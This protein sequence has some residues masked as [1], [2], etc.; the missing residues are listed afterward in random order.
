MTRVFSVALSAIDEARFGIRMARALNVSRADVEPMLAYCRQHQVRLLVARCAA[1]DLAAAQ[2]M[3]AEG[4]RL[5]DTLVHYARDLRRESL[6]ALPDGLVVRPVSPDE[7]A[8]IGQLAARTF[9]G[10]PGHYHADDRLDRRRAD[11]VYI[12]WA[13]RSCAVQD[14]AGAVLAAECNGQLAGFIS[15]RLVSASAAEVP[16]YG[17]DPAFQRQGVGRGLL[18]GGLRWSL[19][20]GA[21]TLHIA[22][23]IINTASQKVWVRLGF[24]PTHAYYTFHKWFD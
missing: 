16:L 19:D 14:A 5:M 13:Q 20:R 21:S 11:E 9:E 10:Y 22:T 23:Q 18:I 4:F 8:A 7:A 15:L 24:E 12:S 1:A 6:P 3:E 17:V 2:T